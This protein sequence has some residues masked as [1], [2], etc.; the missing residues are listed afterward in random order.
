MNVLTKCNILKILLCVIR[1]VNRSNF[2]LP[3]FLEME[4]EK[5]KRKREEKLQQPFQTAFTDN[6]K[7]TSNKTESLP[8]VEPYD[9]P[10]DWPMMWSRAGS[11]LVED[12]GLLR[13][14]RT[15]WQW[16][17]QGRGGSSQSGSYSSKPPTLPRLHLQGTHA[18]SIFWGDTH[19]YKRLTF[20]NSIIWSLY[21]LLFHVCSLGSNCSKM[22]KKCMEKR[23]WR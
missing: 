20:W 17:Q 4:Q 11:H 23:K 1:K 2:C 5:R 12:S 19:T 18:W 13:H 9:H 14:C 16:P 21:L 10:C 7:K 15:Y 3:F 6:I 8:F 22:R